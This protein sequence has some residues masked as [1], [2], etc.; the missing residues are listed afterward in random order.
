MILTAIQ[1]VTLLAAT[2]AH[3]LLGI[4]GK[5]RRRRRG[6]KRKRRNRRRRA[7]TARKRRTEKGTVP[8]RRK[9]RRR[10]R[11]KRSRRTRKRSRARR[12]RKR[13]SKDRTKRRN[14]GQSQKKRRRIRQKKKIRKNDYPILTSP[15]YHQSSTFTTLLLTLVDRY[16]NRCLFS[17][18]QLRIPNFYSHWF[19]NYP[20]FTVALLTI[21]R[22]LS[23]SSIN[24]LA[25]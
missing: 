10:R 9:T 2:P 14:K 1:R 17:T 20:K 5:E 16:V 21:S 7:R 24:F 4:R 15:L 11:T 6:R 25:G 3:R 22:L 13:A 18:S 8:N 23:M 19:L 12:G